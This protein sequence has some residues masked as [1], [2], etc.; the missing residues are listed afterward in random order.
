MEQQRQSPA[1]VRARGPAAW[2]EFVG[3]TLIFVACILGVVNVFASTVEVDQ[4]ASETACMGQ[5]PG[6]E[7]VPMKW[8]RVPWA[9]TLEVNTTGGTVDVRCSRAYVLLGAWSCAALTALPVPVAPSASASASSAPAASSAKTPPR[10]GK[11]IVVRISPASSGSAAPR[12]GKMEL[13]VVRDL[14]G[15]PP[16]QSTQ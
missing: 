3:G 1:R 12:T 8:D 10:S 13:Q 11:P 14:G 9:H 7:A 6:C 16:A 4:L 15:K 2:V 5:P